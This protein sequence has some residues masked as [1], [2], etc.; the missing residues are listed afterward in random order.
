MGTNARL[1]Y[2]DSE[3]DA[4]LYYL[5]GFHVGDPIACLVVEGRNVLVLNDLEKDRAASYPKV[6]EVVRLAARCAP[7]WE[8]R[9]SPTIAASRRSRW[10]ATS[11]SR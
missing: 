11:P 5:T 7:P 2:T 4:D 8:S 10:P 1:F 6:H 9:A 3:R